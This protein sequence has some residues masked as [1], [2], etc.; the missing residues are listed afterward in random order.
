[1]NKKIAIIGCGAISENWHIPAAIDLLGASGVSIVDSNEARL[2]AMAT[3]F[4][5]NSFALSLSELKCSLD[6]VLI[7][8]PPQAHLKIAEEAFRRRLP[9]LCEKPLANTSAECEAII[10]ASK[11]S[12]LSLGVCHTYRFFP[13]RVKL[14][15]MILN[16][17]LGRIRKIDLLQ[18]SPASWPTLTGYSFRKEMVPGGAFFNEGIHSLDFLLWL[19]M[20]AKAYDY[21]DDNLSGVESNVKLRMYCE[22]GTEI[23]MRVSRTCELSNLIRIE[24]ERAKAELD[25]YDMDF[26]R[27]EEGSQKKRIHCS[28]LRGDFTALAREQLND[29]IASIDNKGKPCCTGEEGAEAVSFIE[30]CYGEKK[31]RQL[32]ELVPIPGH[33]W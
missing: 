5:I 26:I 27:L 9:V 32:P 31:K 28:N 11:A 16:G 15:E 21:F 33:M 30:K 22:G 4:S 2:E 3:K 1:M 13:N 14:R 24:G 12:G 23:Y 6:A 20:K 29:F 19:G 17:D 10:A 18:G 7:A 25:I 8:S